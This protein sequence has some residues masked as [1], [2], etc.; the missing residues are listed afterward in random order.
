MQMKRFKRDLDLCVKM[1]RKG[2][3]LLQVPQG[4][5]LDTQRTFHRLT[6]TALAT[7]MQSRPIR[8]QAIARDRIQLGYKYDLFWYRSREMEQLMWWARPK[9]YMNQNNIGGTCTIMCNTWQ[10]A[11]WIRSGKGHHCHHKGQ[12]TCCYACYTISSILTILGVQGSG[13][14]MKA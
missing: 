4:K 11:W 9:Y 14:C 1:S 8:M 7:A 13:L 6:V 5:T 12:L 10:D 3:A 2:A